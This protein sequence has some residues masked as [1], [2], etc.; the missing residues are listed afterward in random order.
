MASGWPR[1]GRLNKCSGHW[2][3]FN[4]LASG[5]VL[6]IHSMLM[7]EPYSVSRELAKLAFLQL[8]L[9]SLCCHLI[10]M[11][12]ICCVLAERLKKFQVGRFLLGWLGWLSFKFLLGG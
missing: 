9:S 4:F 12:S 6:L 11:L 5:S 7:Q 8:V 1:R 3:A 10:F 2:V